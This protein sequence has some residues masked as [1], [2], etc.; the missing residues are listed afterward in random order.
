MEGKKESRLGIQGERRG[1]EDCEEKAKRKSWEYKE[2]EQGRQIGS[3]GKSK[4]EAGK[5][6]R[7]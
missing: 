6:R 2:G 4:M 7:H 5:V 1:Q 3:E